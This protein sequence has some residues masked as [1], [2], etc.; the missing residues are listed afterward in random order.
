MGDDA[1]WMGATAP[2]DARLRSVI[3][4]LVGYEEHTPGPSE[5]A[6]LPGSRV[7]VIVQTASPIE[8]ETAV[9]PAAPQAFVAGLGP[10]SILTRHQGY[11]AGVQLDLHP[12]HARQ[13]L[14]VPLSELAGSIV[15]LD[16]LL[17]PDESGFV[18]HIANLTSWPERTA[19]VERWVGLRWDRGR[20][21]DPRI[22]GALRTVEQCRGD[23]EIGA[24]QARAHLSRPHLVRLFR[25]HV[26]VAPKLFARLRRF[27]E[28][29]TRVREGSRSWAQLAVEL[30]FSDQAHL[31]REV[32]ALSGHTPTELAA[33]LGATVPG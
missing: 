1:S 5:R 21:A 10:G 20:R 14:G 19:A 29:Q 3:R 26:G 9:G 8:L 32:R 4:K 12:G 33:I 31:S 13:V 22:A 24:L 18:D 11:Q 30:G 16:D 7:V 28:L 27:E 25:E 6:E 17:R 15:P 2:V 23:V